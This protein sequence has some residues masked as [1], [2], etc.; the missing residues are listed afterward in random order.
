[1]HHREVIAAGGGTLTDTL[2]LVWAGITVFL[3]FVYI[4]FGAAGPG[5]VL[6]YDGHCMEWVWRFGLYP[7]DRQQTRLVS[8]G[9][10]RT[11]NTATLWLLMRVME[12]ASFVMT[13]KML[14]N[15]KNRAERLCASGLARSIVA[16][17]T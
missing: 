15:L 17:A 4:A 11:P 12:P 8:R 9:A 14:L 16:K 7:L 10:E 13:T 3:M 5:L 6:S 2:H 1:M